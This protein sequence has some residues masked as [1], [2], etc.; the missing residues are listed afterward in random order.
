MPWVR[1]TRDFCWHERPT[2]TVAYKAGMELCVTRR[3]AQEAI[4]A[5]AAEPMKRKPTH[6]QDDRRR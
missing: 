2:A 6:G 5:A 1:F 3:C 4:A